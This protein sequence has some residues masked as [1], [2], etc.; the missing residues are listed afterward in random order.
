M[1]QA[2]AYM[3]HPNELQLREVLGVGGDATVRKGFWQV[4]LDW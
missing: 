1:L 4:G 2:A 3:I